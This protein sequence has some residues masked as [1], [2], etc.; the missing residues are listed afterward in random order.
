[1][2]KC[3]FKTGDLVRVAVFS[4]E[5]D[6]VGIIIKQL[7]WREMLEVAYDKGEVMWHVHFPDTDIIKP[8][9]EKW[10]VLVK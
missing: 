3:K 4:Y 1:M 5:P 9:A 6:E 8:Y 7:N 2:D 10:L